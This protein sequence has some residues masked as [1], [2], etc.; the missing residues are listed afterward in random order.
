M[1]RNRFFSLLSDL[2]TIITGASCWAEPEEGTPYPPVG[3][4]VK[5][6]PKSD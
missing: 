1:Q 2:V 4:A 6:A 5:K 3:W